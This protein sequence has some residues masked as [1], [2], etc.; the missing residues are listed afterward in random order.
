LL[1]EQVDPLLA[2]FCDVGFTL[3]ARADEGEWGA[4]RL[5]VS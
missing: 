2:V 4:L 3:D 1:L 5:R